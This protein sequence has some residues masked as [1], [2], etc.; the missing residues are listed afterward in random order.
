MDSD[1]F[2]DDTP[3][4]K[5]KKLQSQ[6][7]PELSDLVI[8]C[9]AV[10]FSGLASSPNSSMKQ[11]SK[12]KDRKTVRSSSASNSSP[13]TPPLHTAF[14][15]H[16]SRTDTDLLGL[17]RNCKR[18][19]TRSPAVCHQ[20]ASLNENMAK[21]LCR[22]NPLGVIAHTELQLMRT[23]PAGMRIDSSNFNPVIF[24]A[25]GIQLVALNYQTDDTA[26]HIN[27]AMFEQ[28]NSCGYVLKPSLM[29]DH[30]HLLYNRFNPWDKEFDGI[31]PSILTIT[32]I[33][34]Q[35]VCQGN[36]TGSP[37]VEVEIVGLPM[38]CNR[39]KTKIV[40]RNALNPIWKD[41]LTFKV[42]FKELA[43]V[44]FTVSD[45][46]TNHVSTQRVIP[47][48]CLRPG[49]RHVHLR[50]PHNVKLKVSSL[51]I[52]SNV[53]NIDPS[54]R[55]WMTSIQ[56]TGM[57]KDKRKESVQEMSGND[58]DVGEQMFL[59]CVY[60]VS[61]DQ[62]YTILKSA[63]SNTVHDII[64]QA[65]AKARRPGTPGDFTLMEEQAVDQPPGVTSVEKVTQRIMCDAENVFHAQSEWRSS[66]KFILMEK[67]QE[68]LYLSRK[69][70]PLTRQA[71]PRLS[72]KLYKPKKQAKDKDLVLKITKLKDTEEE[73]TG[74]SSM[75]TGLP[76]WDADSHTTETPHVAF[77]LGDDPLPEASVP[78]T[79]PGGESTR[80]S[81]MQKLRK[82][83]LKKFKMWK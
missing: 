68:R 13:N 77:Q 57:N 46:G 9:Q 37:L 16:Q 73:P 17:N 79:P 45:M 4:G 64:T 34:A 58:W 51:F 11:K 7:A 61:R 83:S 78:D 62:P 15:E 82:V 39:Q 74:R 27:T 50:N 18:R 30:K 6:L 8:Y 10:K 81:S 43:F 31:V 52:F 23:Y 55:A 40:P 76:T 24:W 59:V 32:V 65:M 69:P 38:D 75:D 35:Y 53:H 20:V 1:E 36:Y 41:T 54:M 19:S 21:K 3:T 2:E 25:F 42:M 70:V 66:G 12:I 56:R 28:N 49:Y 67:D 48:K 33:S 5:S 29:W 47:L 80:S 71:P 14:N 63:V 60:N 26:T 44:R 22:K 72:D